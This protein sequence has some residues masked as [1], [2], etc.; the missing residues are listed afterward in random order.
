MFRKLNQYEFSMPAISLVAL[1]DS[2]CK[3]RR[4]S[5]KIKSNIAITHH[6]ANEPRK[7]AM[8]LRVFKNFLAKNLFNNVISGLRMTIK[9]AS[10]HLLLPT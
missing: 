3:R 1:Y 9:N 4:T 2:M 6:I 8:I 7:D 5:E 10:H